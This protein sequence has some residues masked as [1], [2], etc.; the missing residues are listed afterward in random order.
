[1][2]EWALRIL[3]PDQKFQMKELYDN[4]PETAQHWDGV[5]EGKKCATFKITTMILLL[6]KTTLTV[7]QKTTILTDLILTQT[8]MKDN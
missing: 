4:D 8:D 1:M 7:T 6:L 3:Q 2:E 5:M